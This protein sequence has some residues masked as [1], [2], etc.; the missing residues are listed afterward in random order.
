MYKP[1]VGDI[2][3]ATS[4]IKPSITVCK[5]ITKMSNDFDYKGDIIP[6]NHVWIEGDNKDSSFDSRMHGPI[7]I[8]L[9]LGKV[10]SWSI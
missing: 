5:R 9:I 3:I 8:N 7:P 2:I 1:K 4:P 6:T 10:I